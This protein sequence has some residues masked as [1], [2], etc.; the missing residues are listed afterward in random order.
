[1]LN[2]RR[3][4]R[5]RGICADGRADEGRRRR[6]RVAA[7]WMSRS[8]GRWRTAVAVVVWLLRQAEDLLLMSK[9]CAGAPVQTIRRQQQC[10]A[11]TPDWC[12]DEVNVRMG[13][14]AKRMDECSRGADVAGGSGAKGGSGVETM[15]Q[16][17]ARRESCRCGAAHG[18]AGSG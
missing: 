7:D 12:R 14:R 3:L 18:Q 15:W 2:S 8:R 11:Q 10:N 13:C 5:G 16:G 1:M 17:R 9:F 4:R 6:G